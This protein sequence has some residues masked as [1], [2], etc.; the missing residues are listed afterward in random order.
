ML[1]AWLSALAGRPATAE[2][3]ADA[4]ARASSLEPSPDGAD[5]VDGWRALLGAALCRDGAERMRT[6]A[7]TALTRAEQDFLNSTYDYLTA[8]A[9]LNF[10]IWLPPVP[11]DPPPPGRP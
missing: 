1:G 3:W 6:D 2:R 9:R 10:A 4:A 8:F 5:P 7:E 11:T